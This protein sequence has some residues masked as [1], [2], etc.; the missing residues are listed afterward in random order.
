MKIHQTFRLDESVIESAKKYAKKENRSLSNV[1]E[2]SII[3]FLKK[4]KLS[5]IKK[6]NQS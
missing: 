3:E 2:T 5:E 6:I 1:Y 4:G